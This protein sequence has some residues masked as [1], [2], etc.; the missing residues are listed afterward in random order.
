MLGPEHVVPVG[1][2]ED[3][4]ASLD[5]CELSDKRLDLVPEDAGIDEAGLACGD[6]GALVVVQEPALPDVEAHVCELGGDPRKNL[7]GLIAVLSPLAGVWGALTRSCV[8]GPV[9][10]RGSVG[11]PRRAE[12]SDDQPLSFSA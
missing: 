12:L 7:E 6:E 11:R 2:G 1:M 8:G 3:H 10:V 4:V 5:A 9:V